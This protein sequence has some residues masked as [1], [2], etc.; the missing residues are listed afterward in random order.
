L[1]NIPIVTAIA[2]TV[3][4][5]RCEVDITDPPT[6]RSVKDGSS[7]RK[8]SPEKSLFHWNI[9]EFFVKNKFS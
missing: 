2:K 4:G 5:D 8:H 1:T 6:T 3:E 9:K 7:Q